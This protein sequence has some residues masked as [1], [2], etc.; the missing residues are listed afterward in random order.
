MDHPTASEV[1][2]S[3]SPHTPKAC[4]ITKSAE[5]PGSTP[6]PMHHHRVDEGSHHDG[7]D[8]VPLDGTTL[9]NGSRDNG[10]RGSGKGPLKEPTSKG[11]V[12]V[13][14]AGGEKK[15]AT[16]NEDIPATS[17]CIPTVGQ[18]P[19][20][21]PPCQGGTAGIHGILEDNVDNVFRPAGTTF[22][23]CEPSLHEENHDGAQ[24]QPKC[25]QVS[26]GHRVSRSLQGV[27]LLLQRGN[28]GR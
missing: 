8:D 3:M 26:V 15:L 2:H 25:V 9:C 19:T 27:N 23:H 5:P 24:H 13:M 28:L 18:S 20:H 1:D 17:Y 12:W 22:Q 16:A 6:D 4:C 21:S 11:S 7:D 14:S 10:C